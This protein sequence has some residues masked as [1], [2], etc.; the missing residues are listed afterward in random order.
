MWA[1]WHR[2]KYVQHGR[3][4]S[5]GLHVEVATGSQLLQLLE[6]GQ[7]VGLLAQIQV[8]LFKMDLF[9]EPFQNGVSRSLFKV[10]LGFP[11]TCANL[12]RSTKVKM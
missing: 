11:D 3:R 8:S 2:S 12:D 9:K 5:L 6:D 7:D 10:T 1:C 4:V